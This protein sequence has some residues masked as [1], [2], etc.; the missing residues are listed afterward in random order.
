M[1]TIKHTNIYVYNGYVLLPEITGKNY[2]Q[3][4]NTFIGSIGEYKDKLFII[5]WD[6]IILA[7]APVVTW[8]GTV[9]VIIHKWV[10]IEIAVKEPS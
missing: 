8:G 2:N 1:I 4:K 7:E 6:R 3:K 10:D 5:T 9:E